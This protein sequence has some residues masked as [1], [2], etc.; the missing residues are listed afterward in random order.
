MSAPL[1]YARIL[2]GLS[3]R[4]SRRSAISRSI[5][6]I[7]ALSKLQPFHLDPELEHPRASRGKR[8]SDG[9]SGLRRPEAEQTSATARAAHLRPRCTRG[10]CTQH[11]FVDHRRRDA[12]RKS[13]AIVPLLG[14]LPAHLVPVASL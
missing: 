14:D 6:A 2:N 13:F 9:G 3:L 10:T 7:A 5:C 11:Q 4:I 12:R 1:R 8:V